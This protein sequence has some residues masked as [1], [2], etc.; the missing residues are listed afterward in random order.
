MKQLLVLATFV[1]ALA[2]CG[3]GD[4]FDAPSPAA[5]PDTRTELESRLERTSVGICNGECRTYPASAAACAGGGIE[6][7]GRTYYRCRVE[8]ERKGGHA[9]PPDTFCAALD[10]AQGHVARPLGDC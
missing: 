5:A 3:G 6:I 10:D 7:E 8:Y 9:P 4:D 2:A 1:L